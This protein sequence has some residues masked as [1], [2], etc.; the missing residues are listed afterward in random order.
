MQA[1]ERV[2]TNVYVLDYWWPSQGHVK[3]L[4][5]GN[6]VAAWI[7]KN[8]KV[9]DKK[10]SDEALKLIREQFPELAAIEARHAQLQA[11]RWSV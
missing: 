8:A 1:G 2:R 6:S 10:R 11:A 9:L 4:S 3:D 5:I 7:A